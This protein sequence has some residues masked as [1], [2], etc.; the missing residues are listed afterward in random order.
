[1][2]E[3][4][5]LGRK[6]AENVDDFVGVLQ[7]KYG[8]LAE[9]L[10]PEKNDY[11]SY[12]IDLDATEAQ[13][14]FYKPES[15]IIKR[16]DSNS[17]TRLCE[18]DVYSKHGRS[19]QLVKSGDI[20]VTL[21]LKALQEGP[22]KLWQDTLIYALNQYIKQRSSYWKIGGLTGCSRAEKIEATKFLLDA[23]KK[24]KVNMFE[25]IEI[26]CYIC[27]PISEEK[28]DLKN[29]IT[30][31]MAWHRNVDEKDFLT[32]SKFFNKLEEIITSAGSTFFLRFTNQ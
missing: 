4:F 1:M 25:P 15:Y 24:D 26:P 18:G 14:L 19:K 9:E 20:N 29:A 7:E 28:S 21:N 3:L 32:N 27:R 6:G 17:N 13:G 31:A 12:Y 2:R 16:E 11:P 30:R 23:L 22:C 5:Y 10:T 8:I